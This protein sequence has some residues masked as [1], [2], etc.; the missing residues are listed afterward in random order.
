MLLQRLKL[1]FLIACMEEVFYNC[2]FFPLFTI[3]YMFLL[4]EISYLKLNIVTCIRPYYGHVKLNINCFPLLWYCA[5]YMHIFFSLTWQFNL[6]LIIQHPETTMS[7][8]I[9]LSRI[10]GA[11]LK[12]TQQAHF[13]C[14]AYW[15]L[16]LEIFFLTFLWWLDN[17]IIACSG[18]KFRMIATN[19]IMVQMIPMMIVMILMVTLLFSISC[20]SFL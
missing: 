16:I 15:I 19:S 11:S 8:T 20:F 2:T 18:C 10:T 3:F 7:M 13:H 5:S 4:N 9:M 14:K 17:I 6:I 12:K 1:I